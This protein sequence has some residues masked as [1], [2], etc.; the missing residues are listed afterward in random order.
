MRLTSVWLA[1]GIVIGVGGCQRTAPQPDAR[2]AHEI[3]WREG[4]VEDALAEAKESG[5]P[6]MLY[7]GAKWCPPCN[8]LKSTL[9]KDA[10]FVE[11][12][13]EFVPVYL[14]GDSAGAQR[15]GERFGISGYPTVIVLRADG[16]E[17]TRL[18]SGATA[19]RLADV[20]R[21]AAGRTTSIETLLDTAAQNPAALSRDD[22]QLL[23]DFDWQNDPR[24][25]SDHARAAALLERLAGAA[26]DGPLKRRFALLALAVGAE[27][28]PG[29]RYALSP[30]QQARI[31]EIVPAVLA[32]PDEVTADRQELSYGIPPLV[33]ALPDA[34]R[35]AALG[36]AL[37]AALDR[38][39]ADATLPIPDRLATVGADIA[40]AK[41]AGGPVSPAVLAKVR[42]RA[43]WADGTAKDAMVRQS[44]IS[45]AADLLH[46]AGD[47]AAARRLLEAELK[48]SASPYY[49]MLDLAS[50]AEDANDGPTA[51]AWA[52]KAFE[53]AQGPATRVQWGIEYSK[54]VLRQ[55]PDDKAAVEASAAAV[56]D[57]LGKNPG[58]YFQRTRVKVAAWGDL[59]RKWS[60]THG[61][62]ALLGRLDARMAGVCAK[63]G[64]EQADCR[65]WTQ[66]A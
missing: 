43:A 36:A 34:G 12:T 27:K 5:K 6:V 49:Y 31:L 62:S 56:I 40:L 64:Q 3:A 13:R 25:F 2:Q 48:R 60:D 15:W 1:L 50:I 55:A 51:I 42:A 38:V 46:D 17:I 14:D 30:A 37:V 61:G 45:N 32:S 41:A 66:A 21:V 58:S 33:A 26:P 57:E 9:F 10:A 24:H 4:D 23:A 28:G 22:W 52:R 39:Y 19:A 8:Q 16:S 44:V 35:R 47:D 11:R 63:Q 59:L 65:K 29:G 7:W 54:T 20:L 18:S 53:T